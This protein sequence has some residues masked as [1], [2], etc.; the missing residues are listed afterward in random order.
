MRKIWKTA[1][2]SL[3]LAAACAA[4][5]KR[6]PPHYASQGAHFAAG[7]ALPNGT[8]HAFLQPAG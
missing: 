7:F 8:V 6:L 1:G 2:A 4:A 5:A 3:V